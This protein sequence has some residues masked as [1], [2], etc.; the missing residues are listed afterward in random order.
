MNLAQIKQ[1]I[2]IFYINKIKHM[3]LE[4]VHIKYKFIL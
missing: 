4:T 1:V 3:E 2:L